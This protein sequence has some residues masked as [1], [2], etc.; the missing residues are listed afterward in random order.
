MSLISAF[1]RKLIL[2]PFGLLIFHTLT[3]VWF[4][5]QIG[6]WEP[7]QIKNTMLWFLTAAVV[8]FFRLPNIAD[9]QDYFRRA[10]TDNLKIIVLLEFFVNFYVFNIIF[11][12]IFIPFTAF[13]GALLAVS[14]TNKKYADVERIINKLLELI[15]LALIG[16]VTYRV[17]TDFK[18]FAQIQTFHD[19]I[20]PIL[21]SILL[22]PLIYVLHVYMVYEQ[23]FMRLQYSIKDEKLRK[24]A[25]KTALF[26]YHLNIPALKRWADALSRENIEQTSDIDELN[27][28]IA[29]L[30]KEEKDPPVVVPFDQGWSPYKISKVLENKGL[31]AGHY[32][33][34]YGNVWFACSPYFEIGEGILPNSI[35]Y[36]IEGNR[37]SANHLKLEMSVNQT[38]Q[39]LEAHKKLCEVASILHFKALGEQMGKMYKKA[40]IDG[41]NVEGY[42]NTKKIRV[43][44][45]HWPNMR[46][47]DVEFS[48]SNI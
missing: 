13:L 12:L 7:S 43:A 24:Y 18:N 41:E 17:V 44:T 33:K 39:A 32:K 3:V 10:L 2:I 40:I 16:Y 23:I 45:K 1:A 28:E 48:I 22:L 46:S 8:Q 27:N 15:G 20:V 25:K 37:E 38:A 29:R 21:L 35:A 30:E 47:Y 14:Q 34:L 9:D 31:K 42:V 36:Y 5:S 11:E 26:K 4:L 19:F 6:L